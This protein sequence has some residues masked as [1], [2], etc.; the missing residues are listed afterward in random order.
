MHITSILCGAALAITLVDVG[1]RH[2]VSKNPKPR[3]YLLHSL[4]NV[5]ITAMCV[6]DVLTVLGPDLPIVGVTSVINRLP[7]C[8]C[9][10]LHIYHALAF[11]L[12]FLDIVH[13]GIMMGVLSIPL[14]KSNSIET[15]VFCNY[16]LFFTCGL[17]G[18]IDYYFMYLVHVKRATPLQEKSIN[19]RLNAYLRSPGIM[20]GAFIVYRKMINAH[21][22]WFLAIPVILSF[23]WNAQYFSGAVS[24]G[25]GQH[26]AELAHQKTDVTN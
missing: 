3:W 11:R 20:Y 1:I 13:H 21:A 15:I 7:M 2:F 19:H 9:L 12:N 16:C 5:A 17:P 8:L 6:N 22:E 18:A 23:F 4:V 10:G 14:L 25:Y 24:Y 26:M